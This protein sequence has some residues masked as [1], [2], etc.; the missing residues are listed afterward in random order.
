MINKIG[1]ILIYILIIVS[2][3]IMLNARQSYGATNSGIIVCNKAEELLR[4]MKKE[5][6]KYEMG[7]SRNT[8]AEARKLKKLSCS[9]YVSLVFQAAGFLKEGTWL[10]HRDAPGSQVKAA[11]QKNT[12]NCE[13]IVVNKQ[14]KDVKDLQAGD[15]VIFRNTIGIFAKKQNGKNYFYICAD[16]TTTN[17]CIKEQG[18]IS[19]NRDYTV[20][21]IVRPNGDNII[22]SI[23]GSN[24]GFSFDSTTE[25]IAGNNNITAAGKTVYIAAGHQSG[26]NITKTSKIAPTSNEESSTGA[27]SGAVSHVSGKAEY[28]LALQISKATQSELEGRGYTVKM[29]RTTNE[30]TLNNAERAVDANESG[31]DIA[32]IIHCDD[33]EGAGD[34]PFAVVPNS[35]SK[36][37]LDETDNR[38]YDEIMKLSDCVVSE[39]RLA[40]GKGN[41][42]NSA[43]CLPQINWTEIPLAYLECGNFMVESDDKDLNDPDYHK[44]LATGIANGIDEYFGITTY[45]NSNS[46]ANEASAED[47]EA[48]TFNG[49]MG[50]VTRNVWN[51]I[52]TFFENHILNNEESTVM[53]NLNPESNSTGTISVG[54]NQDIIASCE[55]VMD[56]WLD[57]NMHY[58]LD[59][60]SGD[61]EYALN[62][63]NI[64]CCGTYVGAVLYH[65]GLLTKEQIGT[66]FNAVQSYP[67]IL[68]NAGWTKVTGNITNWSQAKPGD[69]LVQ[70]D[71]VGNASRHVMIYA[72]NGKV[73]DERTCVTSGDGDAP[74]GE[75]RTHQQ[76]LSKN[77]QVWRAP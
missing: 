74:T 73:Y 66:G 3:I 63:Q 53:Y 46:G 21:C 10:N 28:E 51:S 20:T 77:C 65:S 22:S 29:L 34:G 18:S 61:V 40:V 31:A 41:R 76:S 24:G 37:F 25:G 1:K 50:S 5:G 32:I 52:S 11:Y 64:A 15:C 56:L 44:K 4:L 48:D 8:F 69:V 2:C 30:C 45:S 17:K 13:W 23:D 35:Q 71:T 6:W 47:K 57:R 59:G 72:G 7:S 33:A 38:L 54:G 26:G 67:T 19:F 36:G 42:S 39:T 75:P 58:S 60:L 9:G 12:K 14:L 68:G 55:A 43:Q 62:T 27:T 49:A 70:Y 16:T